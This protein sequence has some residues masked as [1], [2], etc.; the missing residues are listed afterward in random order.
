M[1]S[2]RHLQTAEVYNKLGGVKVSSSFPFVITQLYDCIIPT[3]CTC[4]PICRRFGLTT[5]TH[6]LLGRNWKLSKCYCH[7]SAGNPHFALAQTFRSLLVLK[8]TGR[9]PGH[10]HD[11]I[12]TSIFVHIILV[13]LCAR[14]AHPTH[15][16]MLHMHR[17]P[18]PLTQM[19]KKK[20]TSRKSKSRTFSSAQLLR[21]G[22]YVV[23]AFYVNC[24]PGGL[25]PAL[26]YLTHK[27]IVCFS[28]CF[29]ISL[30]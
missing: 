7:F 5:R 29:G 4:P 10:N 30:C 6:A 15:L 8:E 20:N 14:H 22:R 26:L 23:S 2:N 1:A 16:H 9:H 17:R 19:K 12:Q 13:C 28:V 11:H 21:S 18:T 3:S 27:G 25:S 24:G